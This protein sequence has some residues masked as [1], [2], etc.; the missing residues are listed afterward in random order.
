[1][2]TEALND[3]CSAALVAFVGPEL[4]C[5][6]N[7]FVEALFPYAG[8]GTSAEACSFGLFKSTP[9][10]TQKEKKTELQQILDCSSFP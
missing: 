5:S 9:C 7:S 6:L 3:E 1:M 8:R 10:A 2:L 4:C